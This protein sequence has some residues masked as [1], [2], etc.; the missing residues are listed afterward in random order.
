[1]MPIGGRQCRAGH[2][3][4]AHQQLRRVGGREQFVDEAVDFRV[5]ESID[6]RER[7]LLL[8]EPLAQT[9]GGVGMIEHVPAGLQLHLKLGDR[10]GPGAQGLGQPALK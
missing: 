6:L 10:Q 9:A 1:M 2:L 7:L 5:A 3:V 4:D 8:V